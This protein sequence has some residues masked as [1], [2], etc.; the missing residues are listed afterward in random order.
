MSL[1]AGQNLLHY[2]LI[3]QIGEGGMGV[4]WKAL[5]TTLDREVAIKGLPEAFASDAERLA[6]FQ[7]EAKLL[8]SLNHP[9]I[10]T[11]HGLHEAEGIRFLAMELVAGQDLSKRLAAGALPVKQAL[12]IARQIADALESAHES[13][14]V[15]RDLKPAN[16]VVSDE[17]QVKVLDFGL[18]KPSQD[19]SGEVD[20]SLSPTGPFYS[21]WEKLGQIIESE[22][23][24]MPVGAWNT[25]PSGRVIYWRVRGI[26]FDA[27]E[28]AIIRSDEVWTFLKKY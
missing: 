16:V 23:W 22:D 19:G 5:D 11:I 25:I 8:A 27:A 2:R 15:H 6:R 3:E 17:G 4:V 26:D 7:R 20:L 14:I 13:G 18:A 1:E 21:S 10:A 28:R 12:A 24:R 9:N